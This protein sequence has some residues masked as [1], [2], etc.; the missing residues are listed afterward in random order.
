MDIGKL[1]AVV[2][3]LPTKRPGKIGYDWLIEIAVQF[4]RYNALSSGTV[5]K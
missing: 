5:P 4:L 2:Q 3:C 1:T